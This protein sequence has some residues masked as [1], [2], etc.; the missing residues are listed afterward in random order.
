MNLLWLCIGFLYLILVPL[1]HRL[2]QVC[3][4]QL[5]AGCSCYHLIPI[6]TVDYIHYFDYIGYSDYTHY[7]GYIQ[8]SGYI[9]YSGEIRYFDSRVCGRDR[10]VFWEHLDLVYNLYLCMCMLAPFDFGQLVDMWRS[11]LNQDHNELTYFW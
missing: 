5:D 4:M 9:H 6:D 7:F 11:L 1:A 3:S 10:Q 8:Y 2:R